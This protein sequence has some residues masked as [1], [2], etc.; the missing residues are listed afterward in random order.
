MKHPSTFKLWGNRISKYLDAKLICTGS[1][2]WRARNER[3]IQLV[4]APTLPQDLQLRFDTGVGTGVTG[5]NV[6]PHHP[7]SGSSEP[8]FP[9]DYESDETTGPRMT[10]PACKANLVVFHHISYL[11]YESDETI[12]CGVTVRRR[13]AYL[14]IFKQKHYTILVSS[15]YGSNETT[16]LRITSRTH[17]TNS[18]ILPANVQYLNYESEETRGRRTTVHTREADF[19]DFSSKHGRISVNF[20]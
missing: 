4:A 11:N 2:H 3:L 12:G 15:Y 8:I 18:M 14:T 17:K 5:S 6:P 10:V 1:E 7:I 19:M 9:L 16:E 13:E 20:D